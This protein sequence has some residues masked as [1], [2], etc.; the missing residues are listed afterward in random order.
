MAYTASS[1]YRPHLDVDDFIQEGVWS[2]LEGRDMYY[3]MIT[4][5]RQAS[6]VS[7]WDRETKGVVEP[8]FVEYVDSIHPTDDCGFEQA[9][10]RLD[11][12]KIISRI[13]KI[14]DADVQFGVQAYFLFGLS[15]REI[16]EV[17]GKSH[18]TVRRWLMP[19]IKMLKEEFTC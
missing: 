1:Y 8:S 18:E 10:A 6:P 15:L 14:A 2:W 12:A 7:R 16:A 9:D 4:A 11:A 17:V 3:G 19:T 5:Y 13:D